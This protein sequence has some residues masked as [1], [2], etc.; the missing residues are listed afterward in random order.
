[1][2]FKAALNKTKYLRNQIQFQNYLIKYSNVDN[3]TY[4]REIRENHRNTF[5]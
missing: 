2:T 3:D 4:N 5:P 1:M